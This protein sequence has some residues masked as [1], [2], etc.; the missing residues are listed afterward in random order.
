MPCG[1][2]GT[3]GKCRVDVRDNAPEPTEA[4]CKHLKPKELAQGL[5]LACQLVVD[6]D[7][8][9]FVSEDS[10]FFEQVVLTEGKGREVAHA[11]SVTKRYVEMSE[12][13]VHD[14]RSDVD[15]LKASLSADGEVRIS[16][17]LVRQVP[18]ILRAGDF[19][20][21]A[22]LHGGEVI[23]LEKGDT[24]KNIWG[25]AF[26]IGTTTIVGN[27]VNLATGARAGV[28]SRTNPQ[29]RFGDDVVSRIRYTE[30][31]P[32]GLEELSKCVLNCLNDIIV[33]LAGEVHIDQDDIY[34]VTAVGNTTMSHLLLGIDP[35]PIAHA[36]YVAVFREAIDVNAHAAGVDVN[37]DA[38][39]HVLPN[40]AGFVGSDTVGV[41]LA[42][43]LMHSEEVRLAIDIGTNGEVVIGNRDR[44]LA[45]SCAAGP[46]F[47]GARIRYGM[48]AA[49]GAI[50]KVVFND[51]VSVE[52]IGGGR[53]RGI[54]G[55]GLLDAV[56]EMLRAGIVDS[57]GRFVDPSSM[58]PSVSDGLRKAVVSVDGQPAFVLVDA[59]ESRTGEAIVI[60]QRDVRELQLAKGAIWAGIHVLGLEFGIAPTKVAQ[61]LLAGGFGNFIRRSNA[62]RIGLL[63]D[64]PTSRIEFIGNA[65]AVGARMALM[66][67]AA[68]EEAKRISEKVEYV[69]LAN[70]PDFQTLFME[71]MMFPEV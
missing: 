66:S 36:P 45:C 24:S 28:A 56:A 17:A 27:L 29:V 7:M 64:V 61:V 62:K 9:V 59:E 32:H 33:E 13:T 2:E 8:V 10:R 70:S 44:L 42:S 5:R 15:R 34:E 26:D 40:I 43:G 57:T 21:T 39:L 19:K 16:I 18:R 4:E 38:N 63:P 69:E 71:A 1:G 54:C 14:L 48:R 55:S 22:V 30:E 67:E 31:H 58:P 68:R 25:V 37:A 53:A 49:D 20:V 35:H 46:A 6:R 23:A 41:V 50:S 3:C 60:T 52:V 65:A 51:E 47:E 11:P 12:P